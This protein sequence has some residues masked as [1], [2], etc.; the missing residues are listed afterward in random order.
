MRRSGYVAIAF[1]VLGV[2]CGSTDSSRTSVAPAVSGPVGIA[3]RGASGLAPEHT[4]AAYDLAVELGA[5]Y[6]EHDLQLTADGV[7]VVIH[8]ETLDR[9]ARGPADSCSGLV[10]DKTL[11]QLRSC[12]FGVARSV[13]FAGER[14]VTLDE[15]MQRY[16]ART[17]YYIETKQPEASPGL[18]RALIEV[19]RRHD[20]LPPHGDPPTVIVQ[21]FSTASLEQMHSLAPGLPLLR[22][23]GQGELGDDPGPA[24]SAIA[25]YAN[26]IGPNMGDVDAELV[27]LAHERGL[28]VHPWT[29]NE[30]ADLE[31][32]IGLGVDGLF[33]DRIDRF[34]GL[35]NADR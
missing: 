33:T 34:V 7:L 9:T 23:L 4:H 14:I 32:M 2:G 11:A 31:R 19:L 16:G 29:V 26:G 10:G 24:L 8:D 15:L 1:A 25:T 12:D 13:E 35:M 5:H 18:E 30:M 28:F 6:I 3:H 20:H 22:L 27:A 21:S 17:R